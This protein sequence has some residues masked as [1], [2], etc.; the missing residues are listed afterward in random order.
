MITNRQTDLSLSGCLQFGGMKPCDECLDI[1]IAILTSHVEEVLDCVDVLNTENLKPGLQ[2]TQAPLPPTTATKNVL[3]ESSQ[4]QGS[5]GHD[6][7]RGQE[8]GDVNHFGAALVIVG[9]DGVAAAV[10]AG[11][12]LVTVGDGGRRRRRGRLTAA[13]HEPEGR[14]NVLVPPKP[15]VG[16]SGHVEGLNK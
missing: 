11:R 3:E 14:E 8:A 1:A 6:A 15:P 13:P 4:G 5:A 16:V 9:R 12:R 7:Q 10:A 2:R